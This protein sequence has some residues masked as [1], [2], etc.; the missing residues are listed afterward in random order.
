MGLTTRWY[1]CI[2]TNTT[3]MEPNLITNTSVFDLTPSNIKKVKWQ[4]P[5]WLSRKSIFSTFGIVLNEFYIPRKALKKFVAAN[6]VHITGNVLDV[7]CGS[8]PYQHL[9]NYNTYYGIDI[10][11]PGHCHKNEQIDEY[12]DGIN[13]P[14]ANSTYDNTV[15]FEVLEHVFEPESFL[16]EINRVTKT[17]GKLLLTAPFIWNEHEAPND[18][19]RLTSFGMKHIMQKAGFEVIEHKKLLNGPE[20]FFTLLQVY[21]NDA[22]EVLY[23][24]VKRK[25]IPRILIF[26]FMCPFV[27]V[28]NILS[29]L[30]AKLPRDNRFY[31][32]NGVLAV[33]VKQV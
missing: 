6:S 17:G 5:I 9:F 19:G 2:V 33:K 23:E 21:V 22:Q 31:F 10:E 16:K 18:Y 27:L 20:F 15:C 3:I 32:N 29:I 14:A 13:I 12:Y 1:S 11:N 24:K 4:K 28:L 30:A 8:K 7:G 26:S 25:R